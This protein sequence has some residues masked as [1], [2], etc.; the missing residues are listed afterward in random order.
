MAKKFTY[1]DSADGVEKDAEA[2]ETADH[3]A[4]SAGAGDAA[5]PIIL[6]GAGKLDA[7]FFDLSSIDHGGLGGLADD[8]HTQYT[9]ADGTRAFSG[10]QSMGSNKLTSLADP[11]SATI[12]SASDDAIPM[13]FLASTASGEGA[14][15]I[16][17]EDSAGNYTGTDVEAV[18]AELADLAA[19]PTYTTD[20]TGVSKGDLVHLSGNNIVTKTEI[21]TDPAA[22]RSVGLAGSTA[23]A[24][25]PVRSHS[26]DTI[27]TG[28]LV[29]ATAGD[30]FYWDGSAHTSTVPSTAGNYVWQTGVAVNATDLAVEVRYKKKQS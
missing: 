17:V 14:A 4:S 5:K 25:S 22:N 13:S 9:L 6:D 28:V 27:L 11:T 7:S 8:D 24:A 20:G 16:G 19:G 2:F 18:L 29:G 1:F 12:D 23:G 21:T 15:A 3:V 10:D 30:T 26:N